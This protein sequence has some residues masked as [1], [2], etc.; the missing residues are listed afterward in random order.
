[1]CVF[2]V[3]FSYGGALTSEQGWVNNACCW[4]TSILLTIIIP[5]HSNYFQL[6]YMRREG[7]NS[8]L[9]W[10]SYT[11]SS[12]LYLYKTACNQNR[13]QLMNFIFWSAGCSILR[14][15]G[16]SCS[17]SLNVFYEGLGISKWQFLIK[18]SF[19]NFRAVFCSSFFGH[20][21][22]GSGS[23]FTWNAWCGS[24]SGSTTLHDFAMFIYSII[25]HMR[26]LVQYRRRQQH[27]RLPR[28]F[29]AKYWQKW[30]VLVRGECTNCVVPR[31][32]VHAANYPALSLNLW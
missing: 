16:F 9:I 12:K 1:M 21:N 11:S 17:F 13:I 31:P 7:L 28:I 15:Q 20:Q 5:S 3:H 18:K 6:L 2:I 10:C 32:R 24:L 26:L 27:V 8:F 22:P 23:G 19:E 30:M 14:A 4:Y 29:R 25:E